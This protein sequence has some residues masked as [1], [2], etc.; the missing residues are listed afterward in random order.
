MPIS[1]A[2]LG[3]ARIAQRADHLVA[4]RQAGARDAVRHHLGVAEDR[5]AG[6]K[7]GARGVDEIGR[8][9]E[10]LRGLD[11]AA[12]MDHADRDIGLGLGKARQIGLGAD[13]GEGA[14]VDRVAVVDIVV[15]G[16]RHPCP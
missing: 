2:M 9:H 4:G 14:L 7:R 5:R 8:E 6:G 12:G 13:D 15:G 16:H 3:G 11:Q 1:L 10:M